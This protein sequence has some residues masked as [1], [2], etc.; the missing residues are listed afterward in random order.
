MENEEMT[1]LMAEKGLSGIKVVLNGGSDVM[2]SAT[3]P[4]R[5]FFDDKTIEEQPTHLLVI[6]QRAW[7]LE[8]G[9]STM[10]GERAII[11]ISNGSD[12][13]QF[14]AP[15]RHRI[16]FI[17]FKDPART[18]KQEEGNDFD[19]WTQKVLKQRGR[20]E[21]SFAM[22][23]Q[24]VICRRNLTGEFGCPLTVL[25]IGLVE[26]DVPKEFFATRPESGISRAIWCWA[27]RWFEY[28]P[29]D[30]CAYRKRLILA[31]T[32]QL[33]LMII[34]HVLKYAFAL[35]CSIYLPIARIVTFYFGYRP[36]FL[37]AGFPE[38]WAWEFEPDNVDW[39]LR[40]Y[41]RKS[42]AVWNYKND[43]TTYM[44]I[45]LFELTFLVGFGFLMIAI[46]Y[47]AL[48]SKTLHD[49]IGNYVVEVILFLVTIVFLVKTK[50]IDRSKWWK[51]LC[52]R[53]SERATERA[54]MSKMVVRSPDE[55]VKSK[56]DFY[57][58]WLREFSSASNVPKHVTFKDLPPA[59]KGARIHNFRAKFWDI[60]SRVCRPFPR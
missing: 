17:A 43:K 19:G 52:E 13:I 11:P 33:P 3:I 45:T 27:N 25:A 14:N 24:E 40:K 20:N 22:N 32:L 47:D 54:L 9:D 31:F 23:L 60:K 59:F 16:T 42:Y 51:K 8:K 1:V 55:T 36:V 2:E 48:R 56:P 37:F 15:G 50:L 18:T 29:Q 44:P 46:L 10:L 49:R 57:F 21:Y 30:E 58:E 34:G 35:V 38:L 5:W 41:G 7:E 4:F 6:D 28:T 53:T 39:D 12:F 26:V